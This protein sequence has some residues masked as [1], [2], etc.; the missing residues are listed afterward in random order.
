MQADPRYQHVVTEVQA[1]LASRVQACVEA[2]IAGQACASIRD[3]ASV[4]AARIIC[5]YCRVCRSWRR[6]DW[7]IV[8]GLSR[9]SMIASTDRT[10]RAGVS[11]RLAGSLALA[12]IAVLQGAQIVRAHDVAATLDAIRVADAYGQRRRLQ[13]GS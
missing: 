11:E 1:F 3:S 13:Q 7:P 6:W 2:G 4:N 5:S 12:A 8:V 10:Q 9:K